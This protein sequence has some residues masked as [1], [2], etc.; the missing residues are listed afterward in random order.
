MDQGQDWTVDVAHVLTRIWHDT[1]DGSGLRTAA[2]VVA[3]RDAAGLLD[4]L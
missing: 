2:L 1:R 3:A 4:A